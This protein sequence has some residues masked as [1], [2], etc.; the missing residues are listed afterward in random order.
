MRWRKK[1]NDR[2]APIS[3]EE[4][5]RL[6]AA[7]LGLDEPKIVQ[8]GDEPKKD[9]EAE[10]QRLERSQKQT[11]RKSWQQ[12]SRQQNMKP[13]HR[14]AIPQGKEATAAYN[15]VALPR[16]MLISELEQWNQADAEGKKCTWESMPDQE[17]RAL[18]RDYLLQKGHNS[19]TIKL[20][21]KT[22][23]PCFIGMQAQGER[24]FAPVDNVPLLPGSS[25]RGMVKNIFK[26]ITLGAMRGDEDFNDVH[27]YFR[28]LMSTHAT[29]WNNELC[30]YYKKRM[31]TLNSEKKEVKKC[32]GG[33][34]V[35]KKGKYFIYAAGSHYEKMEECSYK[36]R[37][38]RDSRVCWDYKRQRAYILTGTGFGKG[39]K[40]KIFYLSSDWQHEYPVP[41][42][43]IREYQDDKNRGGVDL[44]LDTKKGNVLYRVE[45]IRK[46]TGNRDTDFETLAPCYYTTD[47]EGRIE[48]FG[49]GRSY[50]IPYSN[51]VGDLVP[52]AVQEQQLDLADAVFGRKECWGSRVS[53]ED[54]RLVEGGREMEAQYRVPLMQPNPTSFQLYLHQTKGQYPQH[55]DAAKE[56]RGYKL[57]WHKDISYEWKDSTD[58]PN[59][60]L[61]HKIAPLAKGAVFSG[62]I[63]FHD[64][65]DVELGA[66]LQV[67]NI[68]PE[69]DIAFKIG[70][71]K[72]LG[73]GSIKITAKLE[74]D[75]PDKYQTL[76]GQD[77]WQPLG[78]QAD[79]AP[80]L[81]AF[82]DAMAPHSDSYKRVMQELTEMLAWDN[83]AK[84]RDWN[85]RIA[86]MSGNVQDGSVDARFKS[87]A[88]LPTVAEVVR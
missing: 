59:T 69:R 74:L 49:H 57:Y 6:K 32:K 1:K 67:F 18:Y 45:D 80:Y 19:G 70:Q 72:S 17:R 34:L 75:R 29:P 43:V 35:R 12:S 50:R 71:G 31:T 42:R 5:L 46:F 44:L 3:F 21:I 61:T 78:D 87:R 85:Q 63:K 23:T 76:F 41:D 88:L 40:T 68:A 16:E 86:S 81:A 36:P 65:S 37:N 38:G 4:Q 15:F 14:E 51:T 27:L 55:W 13:R 60:N 33:F 24:F 10:R 62:A 9:W 79:P 82:S 48:S 11:A 20:E 22:L 54:A 84:H 58:K 53:F 52:A 64:L 56:I 77:G 28:C 30:A 47:K 83:L 7:E 8:K 66:L 25:L 2:Q 39:R 26:I 73:L